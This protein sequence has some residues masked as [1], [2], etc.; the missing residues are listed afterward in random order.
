MRARGEERRDPRRLRRILRIFF[1]T[2]EAHTGKIPGAA[3]GRSILPPA[4]LVL[5]IKAATLS[6]SSFSAA[7]WT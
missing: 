6:C 2:A 1:T 7:S 5:R 4:L 3:Q